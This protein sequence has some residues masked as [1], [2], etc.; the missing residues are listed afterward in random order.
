MS[1]SER[2][3]FLNKTVWQVKCIGIIDK[4]IASWVMI[5]RVQRHNQYTKH[6]GCFIYITP[7]TFLLYQKAKKDREIPSNNHLHILKMKNKTKKVTQFIKQYQLTVWC[8]MK[9]FF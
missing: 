6:I 5:T 4:A 2:V 1:Q 7:L 8:L 9:H 3:S